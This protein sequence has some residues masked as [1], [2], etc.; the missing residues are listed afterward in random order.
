MILKAATKAGAT[1]LWTL[2]PSHF[3]GLAEEKIVVVDLSSA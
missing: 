3:E 1:A 2:N